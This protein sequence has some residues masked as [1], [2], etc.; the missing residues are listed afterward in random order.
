MTSWRLVTSLVI[1][2][3][4]VTHGAGRVNQRKTVIHHRVVANVTVTHYDFNERHHLPSCRLVT[5]FTIVKSL[6]AQDEFIRGTRWYTSGIHQMYV[7]RGA[8]R[9]GTLDLSWWR[10]MYVTSDSPRLHQSRRETS[11]MQEH[12]DVVTS[13]GSD[14][15]VFLFWQDPLVGEHFDVSSRRLRYLNAD[16][17]VRHSVRKT[18]S[19]VKIFLKYH[20]P[21]SQWRYTIGTSLIAPNRRISGGTL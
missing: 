12:F 10:L 8:T 11:V 5:W 15:W 1:H 3:C 18:S 20:R 13:C 21:N 14:Y 19:K 17:W 6:I 4:N 16:S 2:H 9:G 7:T